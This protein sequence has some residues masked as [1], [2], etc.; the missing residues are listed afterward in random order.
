MF[1]MHEYHGVDWSFYDSG[2][3]GN[4]KLHHGVVFL[5]KHLH[6]TKIHYPLITR[7]LQQ[8][9]LFI[10]HNTV[11]SEWWLETTSTLSV[12]SHLKKISHQDFD[13]NDQEIRKKC[14]LKKTISDS[15]LTKEQESVRIRRE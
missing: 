9:S 8:H 11:I 7:L 1:D 2:K 6:V 15:E 3:V 4:L 5:P 14:Y 10:I 13:E 12:L